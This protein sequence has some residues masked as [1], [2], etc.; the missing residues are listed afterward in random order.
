MSLCQNRRRE[1]EKGLKDI[2]FTTM[3]SNSS[4]IKLFPWVFEKENSIFGSTVRALLGF[5]LE[6]HEYPTV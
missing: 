1:Y 4:R 2:I 5:G 6:D 3:R